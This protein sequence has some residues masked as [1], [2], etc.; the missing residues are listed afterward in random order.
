[1]KS[2]FSTFD[3]KDPKTSRPIDLLGSMHILF[4][5]ATKKQKTLWEKMYV[6]QWFTIR[7]PQL[8]LTVESIMASYGI[9]V[10]AALIGNDSDTP[11][12]T[13][14]GFE[15]WKGEI[16]RFGHKFKTTA[17]VL[18][19][20][21]QV[22]E[23]N[24]INPEA[25]IREI[26]NVIFGEYKDA[27]LGC[28]DSVDEVILKALSGG[29]VALFDPAI[30]NPEGREYLMDF[31]MPVTNKRMAAVE[32]SEANVNNAT[33]D[34]LGEIQK[35]IYDYKHLGVEFDSMLMSPKIKYWIIRNIGIRQAVLGIDRGTRIVTNDELDTLMRSM[36]V[37]PIVEINRRTAY[38]KD[39][40]PEVFNPWND[41]VIAFL[42]RTADGKI[43]E[44]Q[45]SIGDD[46]LIP[47]PNVD[48]TDAGDGIRIAKWRQGES[49]GQQAAEFTQATWQAVPVPTVIRA[50]VNYK[51]R[52]I[53]VPYP[54][55]ETVP[56]G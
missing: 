2:I 45:P 25:K 13:S 53:G 8:G 44:V 23:N 39:G 43:G 55:G 9:R 47:D 15:T 3:L 30:D 29:G 11:L 46:V 34:V 27:Y 1:M 49:T 24:H 32:W 56:L 35:I 18:R 51:V 5:E 48:Y 54:S 16:P 50:I 33:I 26:E 7:P 19:D 31:D 4:D 21:M 22:Y 17:K 37:P 36:G 6:D 41:D 28:K 20:L 52:N 38:Q 10:R 14:R 42:P 40:V 12:R